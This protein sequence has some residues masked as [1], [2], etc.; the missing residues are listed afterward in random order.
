MSP[1][2]TKL[3]QTSPAV[4]MRDP[5]S[6]YAAQLFTKGTKKISEKLG[7]E[8]IETIIAALTETRERTISEAADLLFHLTVLLADQNIE[9]DEVMGRVR[10]AHG[11]F[12][13]RRKSSPRR[14]PVLD[15]VGVESF[16]PRSCYT[17]MRNYSAL[18]CSAAYF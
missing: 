16:P 3:Y 12:W 18:R 17:R 9:P 10:N 4:K 6:S 11:H 14:T 13:H 8:A 2:L 15:A 5:E 1:T 7:E